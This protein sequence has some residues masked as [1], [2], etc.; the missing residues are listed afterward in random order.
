MAFGS[1][2]HLALI[3]STAEAF[4]LRLLMARACAADALTFDETWPLRMD[5]CRVRAY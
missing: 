3:M 5:P 2:D 4:K 1:R